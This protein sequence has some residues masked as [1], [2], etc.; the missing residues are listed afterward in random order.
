[1][2]SSAW[3]L[4]IRKCQET[5][6]EKDFWFPVLAYMEFESLH[7]HSHNKEKPEQTEKAKTRL[8]SI[9]EFRS[10]GKSLLPKLDSQIGRYRES[11]L[12]G[13]EAHK[14]ETLPQ[15]ALGRETLNCNGQIAG[16]SVGTKTSE[17]KTPRSPVLGE[18]PYFM[19]FAST[20]STWFLW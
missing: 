19:K 10:Q 9:K 8:R 2:K 18:S 16:D 6:K 3:I 15:P 12:T 7:S 5:K 17:L 4:H 13:A 11:Q 20:S 14:Q 1:M